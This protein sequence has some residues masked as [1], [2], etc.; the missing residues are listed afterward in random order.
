MSVEN[1][2]TLLSI[3]RKKKQK[4][5]KAIQVPFQQ[6]LRI[7]FTPEPQCRYITNTDG[8]SC[9]VLLPMNA[10]VTQVE[11]SGYVVELQTQQP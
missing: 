11:G 9:L 2:E 6:C 7:N 5:V 4:T 10:T 3:Y 1:G 8:T